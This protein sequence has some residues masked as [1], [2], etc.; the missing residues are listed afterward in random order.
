MS[1]ETFASGLAAVVSGVASG[2]LTEAEAETEILSLTNAL[3]GLSVSNPQ[4]S[5]RVVDFLAR[6]EGALIKS[7]PPLADEGRVGAL[8]FSVDERAFYGPK[9]ASGWGEPSVVLD[10]DDAE[11]VSIDV[12]M[13]APGAA[14]EVI[15][16]GTTRRAE[17]VFRIP[18]GEKG[19]KGDTGTLE[20]AEVLTGNPG[21]DVVIENIGTAQAAQL[22]ITIPRGDKG[23][24]GARATIQISAITII[25]A[26]QPPAIRNVG[27]EFDAVFELDI[28]RGLTGTVLN[29]FKGVYDASTTYQAGDI[30]TLFG[31]TY[32]AADGVTNLVGVTPEELS[33]SWDVL[34]KRDDNAE[35]ETVLTSDTVLTAE[36]APPALPVRLDASGATDSTITIT[37]PDD[38]PAGWRRDLFVGGGKVILAPGNNTLIVDGE[39]ID[40]AA[41]TPVLFAGSRITLL[42]T[43]AGIVQRFL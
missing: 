35:G 41:D 7:G 4:L 15:N 37:L 33:P 38:R 1:N 14:P 22:R 17:L 30:V 27:D 5:S 6:I 20:V 34:L 10:G 21:T 9:T 2:A 3:I 19:D 11:I 13:L 26:D 43:G 31:E 24:K 18:R 23:D 29:S 28:P 8:A 32:I 36:I 40:T 25:A 16:N 12:V 39:V 42:A